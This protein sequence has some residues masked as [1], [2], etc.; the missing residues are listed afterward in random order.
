MAAT[1]QE[2]WYEIKNVNINDNDIIII[3]DFPYTRL[4]LLSCIQTTKTLILMI[5]F[6][7]L[8]LYSTNLAGYEEQLSG[9]T[10]AIVQAVYNSVIGSSNS[11]SQ[12]TVSAVCWLGNEA[13]C[14]GDFTSPTVI[15]S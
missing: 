14:V 4:F 2:I 10:E 6:G 15:A 11:T 5:L 7:M 9:V 1:S 8:L 12:G 13:S 3:D